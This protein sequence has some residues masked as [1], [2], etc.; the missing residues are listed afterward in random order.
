MVCR[1]N[2][3]AEGKLPSWFDGRVDRRRFRKASGPR[4]LER[5]TAGGGVLAW[6][7]DGDAERTLFVHCHNVILLLG[8]GGVA[9]RIAAQAMR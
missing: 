6:S 3:V 7:S 5:D 9:R 1:G 8:S 4:S 2:E